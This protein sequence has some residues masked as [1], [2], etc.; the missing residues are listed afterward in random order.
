MKRDTSIDDVSSLR[1]TM[2]DGG[3]W[4]EFQTRTAQRTVQT[5]ITTEGN[6]EDVI[7]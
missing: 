2:Q 7:S 5:S 3:P 4:K 1:K 6:Q